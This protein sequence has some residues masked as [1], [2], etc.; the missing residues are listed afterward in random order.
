MLRD[1]GKVARLRGKDLN[2]ILPARERGQ[3]AEGADRPVGEA[4]Q[5]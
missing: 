2:E 5:G 1:P 3:A 4:V